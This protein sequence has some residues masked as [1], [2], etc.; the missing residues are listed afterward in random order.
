MNFTYVGRLLVT[1]VCVLK[2]VRFVVPVRA[3]VDVQL[4][5]V[6]GDSYHTP[7]QRKQ[8]SEFNCFY[9]HHNARSHKSEVRS[10][11]HSKIRQSNPA[12]LHVNETGIGIESGTVSEKGV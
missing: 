7:A 2:G 8:I 12:H 5:H 3:L 9:L 11:Q 1:L 4:Q 6:H 10:C